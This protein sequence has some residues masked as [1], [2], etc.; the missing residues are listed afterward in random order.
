MKAGVMAATGGG[1]E[2]GNES[3][4]KTSWSSTLPKRNLIKFG[5]FE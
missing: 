5:V 4:G 1:N 3:A 2:V